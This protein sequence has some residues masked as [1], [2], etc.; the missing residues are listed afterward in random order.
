MLYHYLSLAFYTLLLTFLGNALLAYICSTRPGLRGYIAVVQVAAGLAILSSALWWFKSL[1]SLPFLLFLLAGLV[2]MS[3]ALL[4]V[5]R[6]TG[7]G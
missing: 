4:S 7:T 1:T 3:W 6:G 5:L 2:S